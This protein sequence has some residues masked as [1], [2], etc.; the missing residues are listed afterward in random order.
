MCCLTALFVLT[1]N[2]RTGGLE[3]SISDFT[4]ST[5]VNRRTGGLE[6]SARDLNQMANVN[7]RTG[8]LEN[9]SPLFSYLC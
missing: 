4:T 5:G 9:I 6:N 3:M 1:V 2:R 7:R 8:G